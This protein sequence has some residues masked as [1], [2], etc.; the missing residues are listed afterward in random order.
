MKDSQ[1]SYIDIKTLEPQGLLTVN[2]KR[3]N[4]FVAF[5]A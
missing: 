5:L 2:N 1:F 3:G 4:F